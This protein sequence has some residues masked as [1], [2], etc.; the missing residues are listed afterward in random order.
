METPGEIF[1]RLVAALE[2]LVAEEQCVLRSGEIEKVLAVQQRA[3]PIITRLVELRKDPVLADREAEQLR[4]RLAALQAR[5]STSLEIMDTRLAEM[6]AALVALNSA[7]SRLSNLGHAYGA[8]Q[9]A[10]HLTVSRL[11]FSA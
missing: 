7:R 10:G 9:K 3:D 11:S 8:R 4:P 5:R 2:I 1:R 6:R